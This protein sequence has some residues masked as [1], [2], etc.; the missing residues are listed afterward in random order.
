MC[1]QPSYYQALLV[2]L[3]KNN[4]KRSQVLDNKNNGLIVR[5][6]QCGIV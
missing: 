1:V 4:C 3:V 2:L 5:L 6:A